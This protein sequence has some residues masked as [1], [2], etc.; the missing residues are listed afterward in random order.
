MNPLFNPWFT[1]RLIDWLIYASS[2]VRLIDWLIFE[3]KID[4]SLDA[5][6][7]MAFFVVSFQQWSRTLVPSAETRWRPWRFTTKKPVD[8]L[9]SWRGK[10]RSQFLRHH[11]ARAE[12][13]T[14]L[15]SFFSFLFFFYLI[16]IG[17]TNDVFLLVD[18]LTSIIC[19]VIGVLYWCIV[20]DTD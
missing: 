17:I 4:W 16:I 7:L 11:R 14:S 10:F 1:S 19:F 9:W 2:V 8:R 18:C 15:S 3:S 13:E 6:M 20:L 5:V 12:R